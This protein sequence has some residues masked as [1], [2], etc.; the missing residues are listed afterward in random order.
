SP[1]R[2]APTGPMAGRLDRHRFRMARPA[3]EH[4]D[5]RPGAVDDHKGASA[6][7]M[8]ACCPRARARKVPA[9]EIGPERNVRCWA[10]TKIQLPQRRLPFGV[11]DSA[12]F[13]VT[14]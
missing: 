13:F 1:A 4:R 14:S 12:R 9:G 6:R 8:A 5:E 7:I 2:P 11:V 3:D 10:M